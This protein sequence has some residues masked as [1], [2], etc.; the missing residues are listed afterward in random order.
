MN[1]MAK[2]WVVSLHR[3]KLDYLMA[4]IKPSLTG[5][6]SVL[7]LGC[8]SGE[9]SKELIDRGYKVT[10]VDVVDKSKVE[11]LKVVVYD[12]KSLS[13][14][15]DKMFDLVLLVTVLHHIKDYEVVLSEAKRVGKKVLV[16]EDVYENA[17]SRFWTM[18]WDSALNF[19]FFGHPHSNQNDAGW[20]KTFKKLGFQV[21]CEDFG[22]IKE[23]IYEFRQ[24]IYLLK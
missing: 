6:N 14:Y 17:W 5:V 16:I 1:S 23:I 22:K 18:F 15:T 2:K 19:E 4:K 24:K 20:K 10:S 12:G 13:N 11:G 8:G 21:V 3:R 7:D 9:V